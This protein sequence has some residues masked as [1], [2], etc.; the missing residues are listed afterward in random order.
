MEAQGKGNLCDKEGLI[1]F[2]ASVTKPSDAIL[3]ETSNWANGETKRTSYEVHFS[4][5]K[6]W[7]HKLLSDSWMR[8]FS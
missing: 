5:D 6:T 4:V 1:L 2:G 8:T 3:N 7:R